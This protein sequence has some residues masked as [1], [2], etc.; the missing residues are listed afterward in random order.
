M[1]FEIVLYGVPAYS[2][3]GF[4]GWST[5]AL[6]SKNE[7]KILF[8]T[9]S[10]GD[11]MLL[12]NNLEKIGVKIEDIDIVFLSHLHYDHCINAEVFKRCKILTSQEEIDYFLSGRY[13]DVGDKVVPESVVNSLKDVLEGVRGG[14]EIVDGVVTIELPGHTPGSMG[15]LMGDIIF[16]GDALKNAWEFTH[17]IPPRPTFGDVE[18]SLGNYDVIRKSAKVV[19]PGHDMPF[20]LLEDKIEYLANHTVEIFTYR[21]VLKIVQQ[22]KSNFFR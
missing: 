7:T 17:N 13:R 20:R 1:N 15:L 6:L 11:R 16:T 3:R 8:D 14:E 12:L 9:G 4:L 2:S 10:Y 18:R 19:V 21:D 22:H 5:V